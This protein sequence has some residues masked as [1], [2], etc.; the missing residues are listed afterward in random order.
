MLKESSQTNNKEIIAL[1]TYEA[2]RLRPNMYIGQISPMDDKL[3]ILKDGKLQQIDKLWSPGFMHLIIE[4]LENAIDEAKRMNG[5][6]KHIFVSVNFDTNEVSIKDEGNGFHKAN[7]THSKTKKNVVRTAFEELHAGSNF[8]DTSTNILGSHGVGA[9][10]CNILSECFEV[11]TINN[12]HKV[13]CIW[14]NYKIIKEKIEKKSSYDKVGT[15]VKFIP[16]NEVFPSFKWDK[17]LIETYLS[18]K[19]FLINYD[20]SI[21]NLKLNCS[22]IENNVESSI[23]ITTDFLP[24]EHVKIETELGTIIFWQSYENSCSTSFVNGSQCTGIHQRIIN[25]WINNLFNYSLAHHFYETIILLNVPSMLMRFADQNKTKYAV[26]RSEIEEI[27]ENTFKNKLLRL[28]KNSNIS[29]AIE[30]KIEERN[31]DENIK[32]IKKAQKVSKRKISDKYSPS[33]QHKDYLFL[34][35]GISASGSLKQAR[36]SE[37]DGV[38]ALKGK[39]KNTQKLSDL[40]SNTEILEM[41]SILGLDPSE[42]KPPSYK[43]IVI[44][45]DEDCIDENSIV[46]TENEDKQIKDLTYNDKVLTHTNTYKQIK[47]IIKT[48][49]EKYLQ[50]QINGETFCCSENHVLIVFKNNKVQEILAKDLMLTDYVLLKI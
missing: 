14:K 29:K 8:T 37:H 3:P 30:Q 27:L 45:T 23:K 33:S 11:I 34:T 19:Q 12:T 7:S 26:S 31:Y 16:S 44:A 15:E 22:F 35:E 20:K 21:K 10:V 46:I 49:K 17:E 43:N 41:M 13:H 36:N 4:I 48:K 28:I 1:S 32:T 24:E 5:K 47:K 42:K 18:F 6:M 38:Y 2:L 25:D 40:T 9:A 39:I 50:I